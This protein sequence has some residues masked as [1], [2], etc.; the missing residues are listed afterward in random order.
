MF[1]EQFLAFLNLNFETKPSKIDA[2]HQER[3]ISWIYFYFYFDFYFIFESGPTVTM[4][5]LPMFTNIVAYGTKTEKNA[6]IVC[7]TST[8]GFAK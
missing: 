3:I 7:P 5:K 6:K 2:T 8:C 4:N 1:L